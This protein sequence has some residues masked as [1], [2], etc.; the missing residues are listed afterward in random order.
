MA[1][2]TGVLSKSGEGSKEI[3]KVLIQNFIGLQ[4]VLTDM[5]MKI[6]DL[7]NQISKLLELFEVSAKNLA[8]KDF[9]PDRDGRTHREIVAKLDN[10]ISQNKIIARGL[11][12]IHESNP[13][14]T[15]NSDENR[16]NEFFQPRTM[17]P[18]YSSPNEY[19]KSISSDN[20]EDRFKPQ[21]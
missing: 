4:R 11:T 10:L 16:A 15:A 5:A 1:K 20:K 3:D 19:Q 13:L 14:D 7:T 18:Q 17:K 21:F 9:G 2:K 6:D 12:L 8:K